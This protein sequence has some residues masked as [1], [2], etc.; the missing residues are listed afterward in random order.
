MKNLS[1]KKETVRVLSGD[2]LE[3]VAGG[4]HHK[5]SSAHKPGGSLSSAL[6]PTTAVFNTT[7]LHHKKA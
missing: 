4:V 6:K 1:L 7:W 3:S 2:D 5:V